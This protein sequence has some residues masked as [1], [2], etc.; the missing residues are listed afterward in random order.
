MGDALAETTAILGKAKLDESIERLFSVYLNEQA[1]DA[2]RKTIISIYSK[3]GKRSFHRDV[4]PKK[5]IISQLIFV[6]SNEPDEKL[7]N[8]LTD[9]LFDLGIVDS[10]E[11]FDQIM[12]ICLAEIERPEWQRK[13]SAYL[14]I[15]K[16]FLDQPKSNRNVEAKFYPYKEKLMDILNREMKARYW[17]GKESAFSVWCKTLIWFKFDTSNA[18][19]SNAAFEI[20]VRQLSSKNLSMKRAAFVGFN[21]LLENGISF[22]TWFVSASFYRDKLFPVLEGVD[23]SFDDI[24]DEK[25]KPLIVLIQALAAKTI[26]LVFPNKEDV[27]NEVFVSVWTIYLRLLNQSVWNI[28]SAIV[29]GLSTVFMKLRNLELLDRGILE[30]TMNR[31]V[32]CC[33]GNKYVAVRIECVQLLLRL[34]A[35]FSPTNRFTD[36]IALPLLEAFDDSKRINE[37]NEVASKIDLLKSSIVNFMPK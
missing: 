34:V 7:K 37:P 8:E 35:R 11:F 19:S 32:E 15:V 18:N 14:V 25:E 3:I 29:G 9:V 36:E 22:D 12:K 13:K 31:I 26:A 4:F 16:E 20:V 27:Q 28:Q 24:D 21:E 30:D 33:V 6:R 2:V 10:I 23:D 17:K 1:N 5:E